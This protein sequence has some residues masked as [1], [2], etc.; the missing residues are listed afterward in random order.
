[1]KA[2]FPFFIFLLLL[3]SG[4]RTA[5]KLSKTAQ[6]KKPEVAE[7]IIV[8]HKFD[9]DDIEIDTHKDNEEMVTVEESTPLPLYREFIFTEYDRMH[10]RTINHNP[11]DVRDTMCISFESNYCMP[12]PGAKIISQY[13]TPKR[14]THAGIDLKTRPNDTIRAAFDGV[15]R[16]SQNYS[17]YGNVI[18]IRHYNGL[19]TV[20]G[21]NSKNLVR[22]GDRVQAGDPISLMGR[23]GRATTEHLHFE[24]RIKGG[25]IDPNR[26]FDFDRQRPREEAFYL[27]KKGDSYVLKKPSEF[28]G[29][30]RLARREMPAPVQE[31]PVT[32]NS[33]NDF[34]LTSY[35]VQKGDTLY[36]ISR[37]F[38]ITLKRL[39]ELN[40]ISPEKIL[41]IGLKLKVQ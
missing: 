21:H 5:S 33:G 39:C 13:M 41:P 14:P 6:E 36:A 18:A 4:C 20:Y 15:V 22:A 30:Y 24:I 11:F 35:I 3:I 32:S 23:T 7:S 9:E 40:N 8:T 16:M 1:M 34:S 2:N 31:I 26:I 38:G 29:E 17:G 10:V 12:L 37:K 28:E 27:I 19:E 25:V